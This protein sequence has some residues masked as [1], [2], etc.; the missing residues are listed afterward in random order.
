MCEERLHPLIDQAG[1]LLAAGRLRRRDFLRLA[2]LLG[3]SAGAAA[4]LAGGPRPAAAQ[5]LRPRRGGRLT[6][7]G[8]V[9]ALGDPHAL[10]WL[11][12]ASLVHQVCEPLTRTGFD[13]ITRPHLLSHWQ[14]APD[15]KTW[16]LFLRDDVT[17]RNGRRF[18]ADDVV[19]NLRRILDPATGSS[20]LGLMSGYMLEEKL[21][22]GA[23][24]RRLWDASAVE[25]AGDF[26]VRLNLKQPQLAVPEHLFHFT[27]VMLDPEEGGHFGIDS[28]GTGAFRLVEWQ[29]GERA[30]LRA[31]EGAG[32]RGALLDE[33][34]VIDL[35]DEPVA[36]SGALV[37]GQVDGL[38]RC[39]YAVAETLAGRP[40]LTVHRTRTAATA[41]LQMKVDRPPFDDVRVR[42][43]MRLAIDAAEVTRLALRGFGEPAEHHLVAPVHPGY[44]PLPP[45]ARDPA[46]ARALLAEAGHPEGIDITITCKNW[47]QWELD[48]VQV[49]A[50]QYAEAGI[51]CATEVLPPPRFWEV[52]D[53]APLAFVEWAPRPLGFMLLDLTVR[54]GVPWNTTGFADPQIDAL[55]QR[56][57]AEVDIAARRE[58][59]RRIQIRMQ[60]V[61]PMV[62]PSWLS[63]VTVMSDKV[64]GFR[65]HPATLLFA[66]DYFLKS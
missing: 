5:A 20:A 29:V 34:A 9:H 6:L 24:T 53:K 8:R 61:G 56:A 45:L 19:W 64:G 33:L 62:Q 44:A 43:A 32:P 57:G 27:N 35:G 18:T 47:P 59:M 12:P 23:V 41:M 37:S 38:V 31:R 10:A 51:R 13:N 49:M 42:R 48:A 28:N 25:K 60:E 30:V 11:P 39:D 54:S 36:A 21:Q 7:G 3:L 22:D 40:G 4:A 55:L 16:D 46:A 14:V 50:A 17:W 26:H 58:V 52:W 65:L 66:E 1:G 2:T 15:L 63:V